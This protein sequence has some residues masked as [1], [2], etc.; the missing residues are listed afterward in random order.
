MTTDE[1]NTLNSTDKLPEGRYIL[2]HYDGSCFGNPG[3][4]GHAAVLRRMDGDTE[5]RR[6]TVP[7]REA[8][9][10]TNVRMEMTA[11]VAA[12]GAIKPGEAETIVIYGDSSLVTKGMTEW[13]PDWTRKGW[14]N[15]D[16]KPVANR[17]LW[18]RLIAASEGKSIEWRWVKGHAGDQRNKEVDRLARAEMQTARA[19]SFGFAA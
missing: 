8:G 7:G 2:I 17:D 19:V 6:K 13:V 12:L 10:T 14:K 18:E 9:D 15:S 4:G 3:P 5:L 16:G 11:A 1:R